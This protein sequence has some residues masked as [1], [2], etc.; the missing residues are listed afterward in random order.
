MSS[1]YVSGKLAII[2]SYVFIIPD[3]D[4]VDDVFYLPQF[5]K[6]HVDGVG[7]VGARPGAH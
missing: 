1:L 6:N 5:H 7:S 4:S 3:D 2:T